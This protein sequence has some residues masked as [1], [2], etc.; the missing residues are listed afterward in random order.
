MLP[1][2]AVLGAITLITDYL[3]YRKDPE[4]PDLLKGLNPYV[5]AGFATAC[6]LGLTILGKRAAAQFIYFQF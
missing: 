4:F 5:G 3:G 2:V 1:N 6:Y